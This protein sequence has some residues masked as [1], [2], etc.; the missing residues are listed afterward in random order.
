[1]VFN[2]RH[3]SIKTDSINWEK[4][5]SAFASIDFLKPSYNGRFQKD[6]SFI[7]ENNF[8]LI[9]LCEDKKTDI[10]KVEINFDLITRKVKS[11]IF[12]MSETNTIYESEKQLKFYTDSAFSVSGKQNIKL[13]EGVNY[14]VNVRFLKN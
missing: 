12:L 10:K 6:S 13:T 9:F 3:E 1:M 7:N 8:R 5:L 2:G 14:Q 4:E 11:I